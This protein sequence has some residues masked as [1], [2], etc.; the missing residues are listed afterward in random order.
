MVERELYYAT[1]LET[2][3]GTPASTWLYLASVHKGP[4]SYRL[5]R[6]RVWPITE[7]R[8]WLAE[9]AGKS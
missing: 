8:A 4:P 7:F 9:Q 6:R 1:D 5:G 3:T 2:I